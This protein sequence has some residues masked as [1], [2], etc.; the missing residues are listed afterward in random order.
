MTSPPW[1]T[2]F[3]ALLLGR[4]A[5]RRR[6]VLFVL[7]TAQLY[8]VSM[9]VIFQGMGHGLIR[10]PVALTLLACCV[11]VFGVVFTLVRSG[12]SARLDDPVLTFPHALAC[13]FLCVLA[14]VL[15]G[16]DGADIMI[17]MG[18]T[19]VA[20]MFRL[21]PHQI[22]KLGLIS[23]GMLCAAVLHVRLTSPDSL[24]LLVASVQLLMGGS[25]LLLLSLVGKWVSEIRVHLGR[26]ADTL[27]QTLTRLQH[28]ATTDML[29]E[30]LNRR[31]TE[32]HLGR[33]LKMHSR[34]GQ[35]VCVALIDIDHFKRIND[36]FGHHAGDLALRA[37]ADH[38]RGQVRPPDKL[39]RWGGEEF[40]LILPGMNLDD[41]LET[42]ERL[43]IGTNA[44]RIDAHPDLRIALSVGLAA[45]R[46]DD[47][48]ESL[49]D[50]ADQALY[51]AK[52]LGRNRCVVAGVSDSPSPAPSLSEPRH[53]LA[54]PPFCGPL[55]AGGTA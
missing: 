9:V 51:R 14:Y 5:R 7:A 54:R 4:S 18:Q 39:G 33:E 31:V 26:Q 22:L 24:S 45:A 11:L 46:P 17:L 21:R 55:P 29:T 8:M 48:P 23:V 42:L 32:E 50:R 19:I 10:K 40:L 37:L 16:R 36:Q 35:L 44:I 12:W 2:S 53:E 30:L 34:H 28:M 41:A 49:V 3:L 52:R 6:H 47:T 43:R 38:A 15:L 1:L 20:A 25:T 13:Q 27:Q